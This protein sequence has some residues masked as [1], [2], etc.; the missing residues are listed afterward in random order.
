[1]GIGVGLRWERKERGKEEGERGLHNGSYAER[2]LREVGAGR[3]E[4]GL[5]IIEMKDR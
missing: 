5:V 2:R 4:A 3:D 1:M